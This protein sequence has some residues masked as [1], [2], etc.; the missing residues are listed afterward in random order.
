[1]SQSSHRSA[2]VIIDMTHSRVG[3]AATAAV[4]GHGAI[5]RSDAD[6]VFRRVC[7]LVERHRHTNTQ[8]VFIRPPASCAGARDGWRLM[9]ALQP[10]FPDWVVERHGP[11][12]FAGTNLAAQLKAVGVEH[13]ILAGGGI[14]ASYDDALALGFD[15]EAAADAHLGPNPVACAPVSVRS[16]GT[17]TLA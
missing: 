16:A 11:S 10:R 14:D 9:D 17:L 13:L 15:V 3:Q 7:S 12:I 6:F 2:L 4:S 8:I 1:M 5:A